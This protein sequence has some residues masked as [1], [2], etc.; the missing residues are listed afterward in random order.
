MQPDQYDQHESTPLEHRNEATHNS[1]VTLYVSLMTIR[2]VKSVITR[3]IANM[4]E[5]GP[6]RE[7]GDWLEAKRTVV[8]RQKH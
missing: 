7:R 8:H 6:H 1:A 5:P 2:V 4:R 3:Y